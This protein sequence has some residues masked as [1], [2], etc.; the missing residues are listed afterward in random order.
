MVKFIYLTR[1][2]VTVELDKDGQYLCRI[3]SPSGRKIFEQRL[4]VGKNLVSLKNFP[5]G[6]YLLQ[7]HNFSTLQSTTVKVVKQ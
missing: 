1:D 4:E 5:A 2:L 6:I 3:F 7:L